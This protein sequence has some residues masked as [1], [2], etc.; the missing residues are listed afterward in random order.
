MAA[1]WD[2]KGMLSVLRKLPLKPMHPTLL[3][4]NPNV[5][6]RKRGHECSRPEPFG[7]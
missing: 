7:R 2:I 3:E 4:K 6:K 1:L 5:A